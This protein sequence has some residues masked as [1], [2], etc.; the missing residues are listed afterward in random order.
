MSG[1]DFRVIADMCGTS[2]TQIELTY[3]HLNDM[4]RLTNAVADYRVDSDGT[5]RV[6]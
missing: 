5:I 1:S 6:I 2:I 3:Y 4:I